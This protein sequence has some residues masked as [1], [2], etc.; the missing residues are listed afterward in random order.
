MNQSQPVHSGPD[1]LIGTIG[2]ALSFYWDSKLIDIKFWTS[3]VANAMVDL[4]TNK[5]NTEKWR[6]KM[7]KE[8]SW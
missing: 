6:T 7:K 4:P 1:I 2:K 5:I 8:H 3:G